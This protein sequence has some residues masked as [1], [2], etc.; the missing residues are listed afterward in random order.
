MATAKQK[1]AALATVTAAATE[2]EAATI[3]LSAV[4]ERLTHAVNAARDAGAHIVELRAAEAAGRS[5]G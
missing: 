3:A 4:R 2:M 5:S 1:D